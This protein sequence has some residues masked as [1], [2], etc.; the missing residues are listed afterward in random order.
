MSNLGVVSQVVFVDSRAPD[1]QLLIDG[2]GPGG[3]VYVLDSSSDGVQQI[4]DILSANNLTGLASI[5]IVGHGAPGEIDLGSTVLNDADLADHAAALSAIGAALGAGGDLALYACNTAAGETG[6]QFIADLSAYANGIDVAAATHLVGSSDLGGSWT[7]DVANGAPVSAASVPF[8]SAALAG[9]HGELS[10]AIDGQLWFG[11]AGE[12]ASNPVGFVNSDG[13]GQTFVAPSSGTAPFS[14]MQDVGLD[15]AAGF[16]F[17]VDTEGGGGSDPVSLVVGQI[18]TGAQIQAL[19]LNPDGANSAYSVNTLAVDPKNHVVYLGVWGDGAADTGIVKLSYDPTTGIINNGASIFSGSVIDPSYFVVSN[20]AGSSFTNPKAF[21]LDIASQKLYIAANDLDGEDG[22]P[23]DGFPATNG[24][25][26]VDLTSSSPTATLLS[27]QAQFPTSSPA[28]SIVAL[29]VNEDQGII[30]FATE[31]TGTDDTPVALWEMSINGGTATEMSLPAGITPYDIQHSLRLAFDPGSRQLILSHSGDSYV[32]VTPGVYTL[33]MDSAGTGIASGAVLTQA[34]SSNSNAYTTG[35]TFDALATI[36]ALSGTSSQAVQGGATPLALLSTT[37]AGITDRDSGGFLASATVQVTNAAGTAISGDQLYV[38]EAGIS[39]QNGTVTLANGHQFAVAYDVATDTLM[40]ANASG[41]E[42]TFADYQELLGAVTYKDTGTDA[43]N[44]SHPH[45]TVTWQI[46]D[47]AAGNPAGTSN[48]AT[49]TLTIDRAPTTAADT[50]AVKSGGTA[51]GNVLANDLDKDGDTLTVAGFVD[52]V[53]GSIGTVFHGVYGDLTLNADGSYTYLAGVTAGEQAAI[54]SAPAGSHPKEVVTYTVSDGHGGTSSSALA[55]SVDRAPATSAI[56]KMVVEGTSTVTFTRGTSG[57]GALHGDV[58]PDGDAPVITGIQ[59]NGAA[60]ALAQDGALHSFAGTYGTLFIANTGSYSYAA[61]PDIVATIG[62]HPSDVFTLTVGDNGGAATATEQLVLTIDRAPTLLLNADAAAYTADSKPLLLQSAVTISD[63]DGADAISSAKV[64]LTG[65]FVGDQL[66][67]NGSVDGVVTL[68]DGSQ[69][70]VTYSGAGATESLT[71]S[72]LSGVGTQADYQQLIDSIVFSSTSPDPT[73][74]GANATRS[75]IFTVTDVGGAVSSAAGPEAITVHLAPVIDAITA[76]TVGNITNL[77][78]GKVVTIT[79]DFSNTVYVS[80]AP[81]LQLNDGAVAVYSGGTGTGAL[82]FTYTVAPGEN[83]PDLQVLSV[84][85]NNGTIQDRSGHDAVLTNAATDLHLQVDTVLPTASIEADHTSFLVGQSATVTFTFSEAAPGFGLGDVTVSGGVLSNLVHVGLDGSNQDIYAATFTPAVTNTEAGSIR[86]NSGSYS[87]A[88][89]NPGVAS[90][91][92]TFTGDTLAPT[93]SVA[94]DHAVLGAGQT[95]AVTFTFSEAVSG[96]T[97]GDTTASGGTLTNLSHIGLNGSG[98][99]VYTASFTP[100]VTNTEVGS[101]QVNAS[102]Y[103]DVAGNVGAASN[104]V[105]FSGDTLAP[106]VSIAAD[107]TTLLAGQT[108]TVTFT[109]S[110]AV[111]GFGLGD[112]TVSGGALSNLSH[113]GLNGA[114]QDIY[115]AT[116]TPVV[117]NAEAGAVKV[118][119][120]SYSDAAGNAG[121]GSNTINFGGDTL[122]PTVS[123]VGTAGTGISAGGGDLNAGHVVTF[124][125]GMSEIVT[126]NTGGGTPT[127]TLNDGGIATYVGGSGT[128]ALTFSYTVAAGENTNDL[129]VAALNLHGATVHD[130]AGNTADL[131]AA[132]GNPAGVLQIDTTAPTLSA[133]TANP[134]SGIE[135]VGQT[136]SITLAFSEAVGVAGGTPTLSLND[137]GTATYNAAATAALHDPGKLVFDYTVAATDTNTPA[138]AI[139]G[140]GL[141]G[142]SIADL[143]G[144]LANLSNIATTFT[145]LGI[146]SSLIAAKPDNDHVIVN[147]TVSADAAHGVLANDTDSNPLDHLVVSAVNGSAAGIN[148]AIAGNYGALT[149]HADG[150]YSY[151]A[152]G[153]VAASD[154]RFDS[155]GYTASNGHAPPSTSTLTVAVVGNNTAYVQVAP[156]TSATTN[157]GNTVLDGRAGNA[158]LNAANTANAHEFLIGGP[159]DTLNAASFGLDT[160][161]FVGDFGHNTINN[162]H[163]PGSVN[164]IQL[165]QSQFGSVAAVLADL[166]Q[167][168]ADSV[169]TLDPDHVI[170]ITN[171]QVASLT[172]STFHLV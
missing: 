133:V 1:I 51:T 69:Y 40:I 53:A 34:D 45:R 82:T 12:G 131:S 91:T 9:F 42:G 50:N 166:H 18:G 121:A 41:T 111:S 107:H 130:V 152:G 86:L 109:F 172:A 139:T 123:S 118:N 28:H 15:T 112:M 74:G 146:D 24:I 57:T 56:A 46:N 158:T 140:I 81:Q 92:V 49:T 66:S 151:T 26:V 97:L 100:T 32:S 160:F 171:T 71:I 105:N 108:S 143:A 99:D 48:V 6:Q 47:G 154:V 37:P 141:H 58:D 169:L 84:L 136:V 163:L 127:L 35:L 114:H 125:L 25:Y 76:T 167:V 129:A 124:S 155:F 145:G 3:L 16:Y 22:A 30:Y 170:T 63:P 150:S 142:A 137:G 147:Q 148:Q 104:T 75:A 116:F 156:G 52:G 29:A 106:T 101:I 135:G 70:A 2:V 168:G 164:F 72:T 153:N 78:I 14:F 79:V 90:N 68:A 119:A 13:S 31:N 85:L 61:N 55:I 80:G 162:F 132:V 54:A 64:T 134:G 7:L 60:A 110:E 19:S 89:G 21:S 102:S 73:N 93:V 17:A 161:V 88:A 122:V 138:L 117:T 43:S 149:M 126:V 8:T 144:N 120:A 65:G 67:V 11:V 157:F 98:Q 38:S 95:A 27:S 165:Q 5:S 94:V 20:A 10:S 115:T 33:A 44:S 159:G 59:I 103:S 113:V 39:T 4:A 128:S 23:H 62:S 87:D 96:F 36:G 77:G 83:T